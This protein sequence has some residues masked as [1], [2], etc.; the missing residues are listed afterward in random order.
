MYSIKSKRVFIKFKKI[1]FIKIIL[2]TTI[3]VKN[4]IVKLFIIQC[5]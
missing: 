1:K 2:N 3:T 5:H 4:H